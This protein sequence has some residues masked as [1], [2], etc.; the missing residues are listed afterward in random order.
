MNQINYEAPRSIMRVKSLDESMRSCIHRDEESTTDTNTTISR[1]TTASAA[2]TSTSTSSTT[3]PSVKFDAVEIREYK[4]TAG[5]NPSCT[6]GPPI[7]LDWEY[8]PKP[9]HVSLDLYEQFRYGRRRSMFQLKI[10]LHIRLQM[11]Q[12]WGVPTSEIMMAQ[13][14]RQ[15]LSK[16]RAATS[17]KQIKR[18]M[19]KEMRKAILQN[20]KVRI[21][22]VRI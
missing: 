21:K 17:E 15:I 4:V 10:P 8:A 18:E 2:T 22:R 9:R 3:S 6:D 20:L 19:R 1:S 11:L 12:H 16:Q 7:S 13:T 5:D 14:Q